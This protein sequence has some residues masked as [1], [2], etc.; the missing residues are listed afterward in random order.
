MQIQRI[1]TTRK[2]RKH[3]LRRML[4]DTNIL[5][6]NYESNYHYYLRKLSQKYKGK[7]S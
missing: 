7:K 3:S 4:T 1:T 5:G 6:L 2:I